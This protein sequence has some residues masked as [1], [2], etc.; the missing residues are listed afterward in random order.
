MEK[1]HVVKDQNIL[2]DAPVLEK[3]CL[4]GGRRLGTWRRDRCS[5]LH[6]NIK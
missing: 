3:Q 6:I 5:Y 1:P 4:W 2:G